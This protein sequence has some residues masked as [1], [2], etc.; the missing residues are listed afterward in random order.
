MSF[1]KQLE[2][3]QS[4]LLREQPESA[5]FLVEQ[6]LKEQPKPRG[7]HPRKGEEIGGGF[8]VFRRG[9]KTGRISV[10]STLPFEHSNMLEATKEGIRL[11]GKLKGE[12]FAVFQQVYLIPNPTMVSSSNEKAC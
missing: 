11:T 7:A 5:L 10:H 9:K 2:K 8:F 4:A 12:T 1:K 6:L 3:I